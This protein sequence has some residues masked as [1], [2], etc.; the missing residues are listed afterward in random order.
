MRPGQFARV[1]GQERKGC[2]C[3]ETDGQKLCQKTAC[4]APQDHGPPRSGKARAQALQ[5]DPE[6]EADDKKET[7]ARSSKDGDSERQCKRR[8]DEGGAGSDSGMHRRLCD[9]G[10]QKTPV[11]WF[12]K[13]RNGPGTFSISP[14]AFD[15]PTMDSG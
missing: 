7:V 11:I 9:R 12:Q 6:P 5:G 4:L 1:R 3:N 2:Q 10:H 15:Q 8:P 13:L 14:P